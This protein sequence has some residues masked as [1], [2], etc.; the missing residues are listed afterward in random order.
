MLVST[1]KEL[2]CHSPGPLPNEGETV[3]SETRVFVY[4]TI[5]NHVPTGSFPTLLSKFAQRSGLK[6]TVEM[7]ARELWVVA[8]LKA[9]ELLLTNVNVTLGFDSTTQEGVDINRVHITNKDGC[10]V[11]TIDQL[12]WRTAED[13]SHIV[14]S[15]KRLAKVYLA[16]HVNAE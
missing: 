15:V 1:I 7:M 11:T 16:I 4:D 9:A 5:V 10:N 3:P 12:A 13:Y 14:D 2:Q 8:D 6:M